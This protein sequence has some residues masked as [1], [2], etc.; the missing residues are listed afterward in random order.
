MSRSAPCAASLPAE[1][2]TRYPF[3]TL[4]MEGKAPGWLTECPTDE[5]TSIRI[6]RYP[7]GGTAGATC[8]APR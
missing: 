6:Y 3:A 1:I 7:A 5:Q 4:L 2:A 8:P